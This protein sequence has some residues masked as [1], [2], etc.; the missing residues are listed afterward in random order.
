MASATTIKQV[1]ATAVTLNPGVTPFQVGNRI[2]AESTAGA[3]LYGA[4]SP[5]QSN[6]AKYAAFKQT[7]SGNKAFVLG[8]AANVPQNTT[9][10]ALSLANQLRVGGVFGGVA[11]F[12]ARGDQVAPA[13]GFIVAAGGGT[14]AGQADLSTQNSTA[15]AVGVTSVNI[16]EASGTNTILVGDKINFAGDTTDYFATATTVTLDGTGV[17][18]AITPP[19]QVAIPSTGGGTVVTVTSAGGASSKTIIFAEAPSVGQIVEVWILDATDVVTVTGGALTAGRNYDIESYNM[20]VC[21]SNNVDIF[22]L[23]K[24]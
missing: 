20:F 14:A 1:T 13:G 10:G 9:G 11:K 2:M 6:L 18:T 5:A 12:R 4:N 22:P 19:L 15:Y 17:A 8:S 21:D 7:I 24:A 3:T 23:A 16:K